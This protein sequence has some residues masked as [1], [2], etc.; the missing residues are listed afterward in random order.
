MKIILK[1]SSEF[2]VTNVNETKSG[3][4]WF[5]N[6]V[7]LNSVSTKEIDEAFSEDNLE[8]ITLISDNGTETALSGY[9]RLDRAMISHSSG[10]TQ[11]TMQLSKTSAEV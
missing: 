8:K 2:D 7:I 3:N 9:S 5:L 1:N 4:M 11:A 10:V 6:F